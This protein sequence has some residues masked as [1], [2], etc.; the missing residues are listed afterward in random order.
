MRP[1]APSN[2]ARLSEWDPELLNQAFAAATNNI[3]AF[4]RARLRNQAE[5]DDIVQEACL[6][7]LRSDE[8]VENLQGL[9]YRTARNVAIDRYRTGERRA[10][11][12][13]LLVDPSLD[14][15]WR[16]PE[17]HLSYRQEL[18]AVATAESALQ[19]PQAT[20][21]RLYRE[22]Q[23]VATIARTMGLTE[24]SVQRHIAS[25]WAKL[26]RVREN[27]DRGEHGAS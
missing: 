11:L 12:A 18:Q 15:D 22:G 13:A 3:R 14:I 17:R 9:L 4:F 23:S 27:L 19:D 7:V 20:A 25:V 24:R 8:R 2:P 26:H 16:T 21:W 5:A 1:S 6:K 10:R